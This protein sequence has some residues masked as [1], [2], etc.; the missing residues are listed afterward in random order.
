MALLHCHAAPHGQTNQRA[1]HDI[2]PSPQ[3]R[4]HSLRDFVDD[5]WTHAPK[6][7]RRHGSRTSPVN[8]QPC[9][10]HKHSGSDNLPSRL[11]CQGSILRAC[12]SDWSFVRSA[13]RGSMRSKR[14][15]M[16]GPDAAHA[17]ADRPPAAQRRARQARHSPLQG[18]ESLSGCLAR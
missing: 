4:F 7:C 5:S 3:G 9:R 17:N 16:V 8:C 11:G 12:H 2:E 6:H 1:Q 10:A 14:R 15:P 13:A 18:C